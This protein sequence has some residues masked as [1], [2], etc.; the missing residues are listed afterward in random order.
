MEARHADVIEPIDVVAHDLGAHGGLL[1]DRKVRCA[2]GG[3]EHDAASAGH[4]QA[5]LDNP[6][7]FMKPVVRHER[8]HRVKSL[9]VRPR[10]EQAVAPVDDGLGDPG[11]LL[12]PL[13]LSVDDLGEA[14][15]GGTVVVDARKAEVFDRVGVQEFTGAAGGCVGV[16]LAV[17]HGVEQRAEGIHRLT[18]SRARP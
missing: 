8:G 15:A 14:L 10:D 3:N 9:G 16:E 13:S 12:W 11:D 1:R 7:H 18:R 2:C 6:G 17:A 5:A 4:V